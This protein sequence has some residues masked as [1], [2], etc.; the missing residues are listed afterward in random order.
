ML[1]IQEL[2]DIQPELNCYAASKVKRAM[3]ELACITKQVITLGAAA[4]EDTITLKV[5]VRDFKIR[6][7]RC[8]SGR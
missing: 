3:K 8:V 7:A 4:F 5:N 2:S 1:P 6:L